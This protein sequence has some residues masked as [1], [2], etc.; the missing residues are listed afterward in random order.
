VKLL[1]KYLVTSTI[2][3]FI[4]ILIL[5]NGILLIGYFFQSLEMLLT[6][7]PGLFIL[8][9]FIATR[10][11]QN[12]LFT[13]PISGLVAILSIGTRL[14]TKNELI[15]ITSSGI[16]KTKIYFPL[17]LFSLFLSITC[18]FL[19]EF[20]IPQANKSHFL[21]KQKIKK[22]TP[23]V[24]P[25]SIKLGN[26]FVHIGSLEGNIIKELKIQREDLVISGEICEYKNKK[27]HLKSGLERKIEKG[28][29]KREK[30][31]LILNKFPN[32]EEIKLL[33]LS[34]YEFIGPTK[35]FKAIR[36]AKREGVECKNYIKELHFKIAFSFA[37]LVLTMI[38][39]GIITRG[40]KFGLYGNVGI[41]LLISFFYWQGILFFKSLD[42][43]SILSSWAGNI[44][45][46]SIA[47]R[48]LF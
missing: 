34:D 16:S 30:R 3:P 42:A 33:A 17:I 9:E 8:L 15:L 19:C 22:V 37:S 26:S 39:L 46:I 38:G 27:W 12:L 41:A 21:V 43:S 20:L 18:L 11:P 29:V 25:I 23:P 31:V 14:I 45:G 48:L 7:K 10:I 35:L 24:K 13:I 44:I 47:I 40:G 2:R 28:E 4:I 6:K 36:I 32:P 5:A 1:F